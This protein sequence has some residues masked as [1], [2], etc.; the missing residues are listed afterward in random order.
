MQRWQDLGSSPNPRSKAMMRVLLP[1]SAL[2]ALHL[3]GCG[4]CD[5]EAAAKSAA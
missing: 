4:G 1:L 2:L 3:N 5:E